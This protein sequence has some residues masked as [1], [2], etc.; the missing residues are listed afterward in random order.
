M[1]RDRE[2]AAKYCAPYGKLEEMMSR[3]GK[4][5]ISIINGVKATMKG[6]SVTMQGPQ[7]SLTL[8]LPN[9]PLVDVKVSES[10]ITV[11]R[12]VESADARR[13]QGLVRALIQNQLTGVAEGY[14]RELDIVG[15]GYKAEVKGKDLLLSVG[16][17]SPKVY[18]IPEGLKVTVEKNTR[19][20]LASNDKWLIGQAASQ[21]R[22]VRPPEPYKGKGIRHFDEKIKKK[23]GKAAVGTG[24]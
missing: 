21:I 8:E 4:R 5:P 6:N 3:I 16:Y 14:R 13:Q 18:R 10:E 1:L 11:S 20:F 7:G 19:I 24:G 22:K 15:V 9:T 12:K 23:V 17:A 2:S